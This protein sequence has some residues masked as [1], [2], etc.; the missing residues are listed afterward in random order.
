MTKK[1]HVTSRSFMLRLTH[2]PQDVLE[3]R[4]LA[5]YWMCWANV[6]TLRETEFC[7]RRSETAA[8]WGVCCVVLKQNA[9]NGVCIP[10][11]S[12]KPMEG[13]CQQA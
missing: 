13:E 2:R 10:H 9:L 8:S 6:H 5:A 1:K 7:L 12:A 4:D 3:E 11:D